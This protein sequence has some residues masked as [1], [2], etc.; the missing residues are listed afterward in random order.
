MRE[1]FVPRLGTLSTMLRSLV[2]FVLAAPW[3]QAQVPDRPLHLRD[4]TSATCGYGTAHDDR[5]ID[6]LPLAVGEVTAERGIGTHAPAELTFAVPANQ[7]W[8]T[9]WFGVAAERGT[10]GSIALRVLADEREVLTS[11]VTR[12]GAA[13]LWIAAPILGAKTMRL[14]V[15]DAGDGNGADHANLLWPTWRGH[16]VAPE[17]HLPGV[18]TFAGQGKAPA[19]SLL[20]ADRPAQQFVEA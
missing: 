14:V 4:A 2:A 12:G 18:V 9:C 3:L 8:F 20:F 1:Q 15:T 6:G 17:G 7:R 10:N 19:D 13:P 11:A 5:S 16:E